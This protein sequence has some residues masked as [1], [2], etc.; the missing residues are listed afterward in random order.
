[1][2]GEI[3]HYKKHLGLQIGQYCQVHQEYTPCNINQLRTKGAI[4]M[5]PRGNLQGRFKFM[6]LRSMKNII[7]RSWNMIPITDTVI[8]QFNILVRDHQQILLF[9]NRKGRLIRYSNIKITGV[10]GDENEAPLKIENKV[11][12]IIKRIKRRS[13][14]SRRTKPV[15]KPSEY[16]CSPQNKD[17][18]EQ[19][20][21]RKAYHPTQFR[22]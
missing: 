6:I 13:I 15:N 20:N 1:M 9:N 14:T 3:T 22:T 8:D 18:P 4:Y 12:H 2:T 5:E 19:H 7:G 11:I 21:F 10:D 16:N 17:P